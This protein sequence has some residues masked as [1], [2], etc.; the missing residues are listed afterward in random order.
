MLI[1]L[2]TT[3]LSTFTVFALLTINYLLCRRATWPNTQ[4]AKKTSWQQNR[5]NLHQTINPKTRCKDWKNWTLQGRSPSK[6][7]K[8]KVREKGNRQKQQKSRG[9]LDNNTAIAIR[10]GALRLKRYIHPSRTRILTIFSTNC[11]S[12]TF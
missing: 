1:L 10:T 3:H 7:K 4:S 8:K 9:F 6:K 2:C 11:T 5:R 12:S